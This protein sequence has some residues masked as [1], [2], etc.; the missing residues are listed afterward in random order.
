MNQTELNAVCCVL[1]AKLNNDTQLA[2]CYQNVIR[3][4]K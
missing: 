4:G 3:N 1:Q 2:L